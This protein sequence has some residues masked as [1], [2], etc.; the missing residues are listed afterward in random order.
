[1]KLFTILFIIFLDQFLKTIVSNNLE[2]YEIIKIFSFLNIVNI[3]NTGIS[4]G[5]FS[6][7]L[8]FWVILIIVGLVII[9]LIYWLL[10]SESNIEKW[11]LI[12]ILGGAFANFFD[13]LI[14]KHVIDYI[15]FQYNKFYW[16]AFNLAD[17]AIT[18]GIISLIVATF[19]SYKYKG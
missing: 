5:L 18:I 9:A 11:G 2:E 19:K 15:Y 6:G 12:F 14:N 1:M 7:I 17:I 13:R 3:H 8:S 4:F 16:P 10:N